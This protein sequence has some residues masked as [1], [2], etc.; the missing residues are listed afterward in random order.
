MSGPS[1]SPVSA[2]AVRLS[3]AM[4]SS[5]PSS[6]SH[7]D[8]ACE[9]ARPDAVVRGSVV[10]D[11]EVGGPVEPAWREAGAA[12]KAASG[13][14]LTSGIAAVAP[15]SLAKAASAI[16][17]PMDG[18]AVCTREAVKTCTVAARAAGIDRAS[19]EAA[20][21]EDQDAEVE[22]DAS[23]A[24]AEAGTGK[25]PRSS[26]QKYCTPGMFGRVSSTSRSC[27]R[28]ERSSPYMRTWPGP[29]E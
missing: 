17:M 22:E 15:L 1:S 21:P 26:R 4:A 18:A 11:R 16:A 14:P 13:V 6:S 9:G 23:G 3:A 12:A 10:A 7:A 19:P 28:R 24:G 8:T 27:V 25:V 29:G 2:T 20:S 5:S